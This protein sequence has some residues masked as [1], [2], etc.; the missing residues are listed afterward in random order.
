M[1]NYQYRYYHDHYKKL[2]KR[3]NLVLT[4]KEYQDFEQW[5]KAHQISVNQG[6]RELAL[7]Q[8]NQIKPI[9]PQWEQWV[10]LLHRDL[11]QLSNDIRQ[12]CTPLAQK[13]APEILKILN[14]LFVHLQ[15]L[16]NTWEKLTPNP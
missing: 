10:H 11:H 4:L 7:A 9:S 13:P 8:L 12:L 14:A 15:H 2:K 1:N 3:A 6:I 16:A 5:S